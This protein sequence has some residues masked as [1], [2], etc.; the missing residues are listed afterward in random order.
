M[1]TFKFRIIKI[2]DPI[3]QSTYFIVQEKGW[4]FWRTFY[5]SEMVEGTIFREK[6][7]FFSRSA[8]H[9]FINDEIEYRQR[10]IDKDKPYKSIVD[11][12]EFTIS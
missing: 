11:V 2:E 5:E 3:C 12:L 9:A 10:Q 6:K 8:A 1:K 7:T 4:F